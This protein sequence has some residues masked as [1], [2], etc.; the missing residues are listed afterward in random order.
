MMANITIRAC[1]SSDKKVW[2]EMN[3]A[4]MDYE[5]A[6]ENAWVDPRSYGDLSEDFD[7][8]MTGKVGLQ[9]MMVEQNAECIGF[10]NMQS[11]YSVW[12]HGMVL[13]VDDFFIDSQMR[14]R[15]VGTRALEALK[16][17]AQAHQVVRIDLLAEHTNPGARSFYKALGFT[18]Q[19]VTMNLWHANR[20]NK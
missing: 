8:A 2:I 1:N 9:L 7:Q 15:G 19:N 20:G 16:E 18:Q 14:G 5:Y 11:F 12:A 4:F 10:I 17:Y 13:F 6:P 3:Q